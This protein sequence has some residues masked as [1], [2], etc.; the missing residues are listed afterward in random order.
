LCIRCCRRPMRTHTPSKNQPG[1]SNTLLQ[2]VSLFLPRRAAGPQLAGVGRT[3]PR[4]R[5][6]SHSG[7]PARGRTFSAPIWGMERTRGVG[8]RSGVREPCV[9]AR[10]DGRP[11]APRSQRPWASLCQLRSITSSR[12]IRST[13]ASLRNTGE[14]RLP[15]L[16]GAESASC[17]VFWAAACTSPAE[18]R[19]PAQANQRGLAT[20][21]A[22]DGDAEEVGMHTTHRLGALAALKQPRLGSG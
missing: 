11:N 1:N 8:M 13:I 2:H 6:R 4:Q 22:E 21:T 3:D 12:S 19:N 7:Q 20:G 9:S 17:H 18:T 14:L 10:P 16:G 5:C 15:V